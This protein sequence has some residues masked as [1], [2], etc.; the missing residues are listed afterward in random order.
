MLCKDIAGKQA[1]SMP[2]PH[3]TINALAQTTDQG[4]MG[5]AYSGGHSPAMLP[6]WSYIFLT[7]SIWILEIP[8]HV[9]VPLIPSYPCKAQ[10]CFVLVPGMP[11]QARANLVGDDSSE[12]S[13]LGESSEEE[14][15]RVGSPLLTARPASRASAALAPGRPMTASQHLQRSASGMGPRAL[16]SPGEHDDDDDDSF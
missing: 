13:T 3:G 4:H 1:T 15:S 7:V 6:D 12:A 10:V 16:H 2:T 14:D 11:V 5:I 8:C 9:L